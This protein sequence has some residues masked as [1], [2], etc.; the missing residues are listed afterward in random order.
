[1]MTGERSGTFTDAKAMDA[2][3][4]FLAVLACLAALAG[5]GP[6]ADAATTAVPQDQNQTKE[7]LSSRLAETNGTL[8]PPPVDQGMQKTPTQ[9]GTMPVIAPPGTAG[10]KPGAVA[11]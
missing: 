10:G 11:K 5:A 9:H 4:R 2:M 3:T 1:M 8:R 7:P 6:A